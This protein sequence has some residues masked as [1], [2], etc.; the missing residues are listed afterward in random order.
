M[1]NRTEY[2]SI[3]LAA[4]K[5]TRLGDITKETPKPLLKIGSTT[6]LEH[7]LRFVHAIGVAKTIVIARYQYEKLESAVSDYNQ[8]NNEQVKVIKVG[9]GTLQGFADALP[10]VLEGNILVRDSDYI[11]SHETLKAVKNT[12]SGTS[13]YCSFDLTGDVDDVM[14]VKTDGKGKMVAAS[15]TLTDFDAVYI[16]IFTLAES[17]MNDVRDI[18]K[19]QF[20]KRPKEE[21]RVEV[22]FD[23]LVVLGKDVLIKDVGKKDYIEVDTEEELKEAQEAYKNNSDKYTL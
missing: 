20:S 4:G 17:D 15:K 18:I 3:I 11:F 12:M 19:D 9:Y 8:K 1:N 6:L 23:E 2:T 5:G 22:L 7:A 10:E 14:R 13:M 21:P 16:G